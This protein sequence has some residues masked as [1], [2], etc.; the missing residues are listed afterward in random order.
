MQ[1]DVSALHN[2][3][4]EKNGY[5]DEHI[6]FAAVKQKRVNCNLNPNTIAIKTLILV[7]F[8]QIYVVLCTYT[9]AQTY[10]GPA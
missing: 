4:V 7:S 2:G 3:T 1:Y 6:K 10:P 8:P 5:V 9:A